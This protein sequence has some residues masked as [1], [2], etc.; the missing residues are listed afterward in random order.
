MHS[1]THQLIQINLKS[2]QKKK[3]K[4]NLKSVLPL[5]KQDKYPYLHARIR[6]IL[7]MIRQKTAEFWKILESKS[8]QH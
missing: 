5:L 7:T 2:L 6:S 8:R 1:Y 4:N 3:K